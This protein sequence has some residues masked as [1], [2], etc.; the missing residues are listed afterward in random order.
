MARQ[1]RASVLHSCLSD[2]E[3]GDMGRWVGSD[4]DEAEGA[5]LENSARAARASR[6]GVGWE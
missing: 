2:D 6:W 3:D 5:M 4:E 1:R